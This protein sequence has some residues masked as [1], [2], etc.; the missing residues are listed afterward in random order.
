MLLP[1][2][3]GDLLLRLA[4][5][6]I[7][8]PLWSSTKFSAI[9]SRSSTSPPEK[10]ARRLVLAAKDGMRDVHGRAGSSASR[11]TCGP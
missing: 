2:Q 5:A 4:D 6:E 1:Y 3:L 10:A 8:E 9:S 11:M 7:Y